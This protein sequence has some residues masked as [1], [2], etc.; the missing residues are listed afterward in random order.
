MFGNPDFFFQLS[1]P[2]TNVKE[3]V[4]PAFAWNHGDVQQE[5]GNTWVGMAGPGVAKGGVDSKT[6]TDHTN[7]RPT[8]LSLLGL[9]DDYTDDGH[10]L[11]QAL[12]TKPA[13]HSAARRSQLSSRP[14]TEVNSPF[15]QFALAN[16]SSTLALKSTDET[17]YNSIEDPDRG[18]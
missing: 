14:T 15:G 18:A 3:C 9:K 10:V 8:I 7:V 4:A 5:I 13:V 1:N 16:T 6:W 12:K 2:C 11:V 17:Q